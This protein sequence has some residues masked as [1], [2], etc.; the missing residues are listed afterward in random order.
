MRRG[1]V[2]GILGILICST[3][4]GCV[5]TP[6]VYNSACE[7]TTETV[8]ATEKRKISSQEE[9]T[10]ISIWLSANDSTSANADAQGSIVYDVTMAA[11]CV[12]EDGVITSCVIDSIPASVA[13]DQKGK[14]TTDLNAEILSKNELGE[15]YGMKTYGGASYEWNEQAA[16][17]A[18]YAVG[19]TVEELKLGAID[20]HG[21]AKDADLASVATI[22]LGNYVSIIEEAVNQATYLG[23]EEGDVLY[24]E[25]ENS[26]KNSKGSTDEEDGVAQ[27]DAKITVWTQRDDN[28]TSSLVHEVQAK[29]GFNDQGEITTDLEQEIQRKKE[30]EEG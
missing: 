28:V 7:N 30:S 13:F 12:D 25:A 29:V 20:E 27:F 26:L 11:V 2:A 6:V 5:G 17:L 18:N 10:G 22:Y 9:K 1:V 15:A 16:A 4:T 14:I 8:K 21:K 19:K 3:F 24:L 23:A